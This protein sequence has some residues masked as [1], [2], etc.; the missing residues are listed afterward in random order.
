MVVVNASLFRG[1]EGGELDRGRLRVFEV[2]ATRIASEAGNALAASLVL[3][4][5]YASVTGMVG[6][7]SLVAAMLDALP[8][9]RRQHAASNEQALRA[10]FAAA[11]AGAAPAWQDEGRAA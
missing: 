4:G 1:E 7:D 3:V 9:Y 2:E 10:G 5:A 6:A 8:P 11:P